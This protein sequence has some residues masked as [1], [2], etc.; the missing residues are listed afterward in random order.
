MQETNL[1]NEVSF[2]IL[3]IFEK[4][5]N[6]MKSNFGEES[7]STEILDKVLSLILQFLKTNHTISFLPHLYASFRFV[8][9]NLN[10]YLKLIFLLTLEL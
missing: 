7:L 3:G 4:F 8:Y 1:S 9:L 5:V 2:I 10:H 6:V